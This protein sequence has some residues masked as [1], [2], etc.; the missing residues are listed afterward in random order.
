[1]YKETCVCINIIILLCNLVDNCTVCISI[2]AANSFNV[3][4]ADVLLALY[5]LTN[6]YIANDELI[7]K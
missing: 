7:T 6:S 1:M 4:V 2:S 3:K 5:I